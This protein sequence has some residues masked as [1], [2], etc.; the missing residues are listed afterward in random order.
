[1][2][3]VLIVLFFG[4]TQTHAAGK[5]LLQPDA[6]THKDFLIQPWSPSKQDLVVFKDPS[7][8]YCVR[9]MK[10][11]ASLSEYNVFV[12][13]SAILGERS[14]YHVNRY[15]HCDSPIGAKVQNAMIE[16]KLPDC[17]GEV[18]QALFDLNNKMVEQY[19]PNSVPQ[20]WL[21]GRQVS[22]NQLKNTHSDSSPG[23]MPPSG[24]VIPWSRYQANQISL[25]E[26]DEKPAD[27]PKLALVVK[28]ENQLELDQLTKLNENYELYIF[29]SGV[30][31][32]SCPKA[33][34]CDFLSEKGTK[35]TAEFSLLM[36]I[37]NQ[38]GPAL[39][40]AG[41]VLNA[42]KTQKLL[43]R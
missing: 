22:R 13:W 25:E 34:S 26:S 33:F 4:S 31:N 1:M 27:K 37:E 41:Q 7:C 28:S 35:N 19:S 42:S 29:A 8:P 36:G 3:G 9:D 24:V 17:A 38:Q 40:L 14:N 11:I 18:N 23:I 39:V 6:R 30:S 10:K 2:L 15:F 32:M 21:G 12:F 43:A 5:T 16:R 20:Y